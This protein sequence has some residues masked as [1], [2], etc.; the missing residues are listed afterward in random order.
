[1][2]VLKTNLIVTLRAES[3]QRIRDTRLERLTLEGFEKDGYKH[4]PE[5]YGCHYGELPA[6]F[7]TFQAKVPCVIPHFSDWF[8]H[9]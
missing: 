1:M 8:V 6:D 2:K 7:T 3:S 9:F 5:M 4:R